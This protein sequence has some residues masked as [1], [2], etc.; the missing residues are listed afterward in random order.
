MIGQPRQRPKAHLSTKGPKAARRCAGPPGSPLASPSNTH[1]SSSPCERYQPEGEHA[2]RY[3][4]VQLQR[5]SARCASSPCPYSL[6]HPQSTPSLS[7]PPSNRN[8]S[9]QSLGVPK[10]LHQSILSLELY[11]RQKHASRAC[12]VNVFASLDKSGGRAINNNS[13]LPTLRYTAVSGSTNIPSTR[14][15]LWRQFTFKHV[16]ELTRPDS[17]FVHELVAMGKKR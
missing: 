16:A 12:E 4:L 1:P 14:I 13:T 7:V 3:F 10:S 5:L 6:C 9:H 11:V 17:D 15:S 8:V 2:P